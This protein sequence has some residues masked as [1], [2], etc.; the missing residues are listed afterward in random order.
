MVVKFDTSGVG[1]ELNVAEDVLEFK[2][3]G[4]GSELEASK[5]DDSELEVSG[6]G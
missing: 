4:I 2:D 1:L 6:E 5:V 3:S